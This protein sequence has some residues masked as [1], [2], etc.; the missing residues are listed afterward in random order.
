MPVFIR[1]TALGWRDVR[2]L[3]RLTVFSKHLTVYRS[4]DNVYLQYRSHDRSGLK[5]ERVKRA[6]LVETKRL[7]PPCKREQARIP[8]GSLPIN[9]HK[10]VT[11]PRV[12]I[13]LITMYTDSELRFVCRSGNVDR[14]STNR[15]N[16]GLNNHEPITSQT[17]R[18]L[19]TCRDENIGREFG[20]RSTRWPWKIPRIVADVDPP[21]ACTR[22]DIDVCVASSP[23]GSRTI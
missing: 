3:A 8:R 15:I 6:R 16:Y 22:F 20:H 19:S 17:Q 4:Q 9:K 14:N 18:D 10:I 1:D 21:Y 13:R 2:R 11:R 5:E 23:T 7:V 12:S